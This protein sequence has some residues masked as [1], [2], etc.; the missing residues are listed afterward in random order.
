MMPKKTSTK[1]TRGAQ[2]RRLPGR[3]KIIRTGNRGRP[4]KQYRVANGRM[5]LEES[6]EYANMAEISLKEA[7]S[8]NEVDEW[9]A[10]IRDEFRALI[11]NET[12]EMII[13]QKI[14]V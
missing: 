1:S 11:E 7:L 10:A 3:P 4:V 14:K 9:K 5:A 12:R 2:P 13:D 8:G 6:S